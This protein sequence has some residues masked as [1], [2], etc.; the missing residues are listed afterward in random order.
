M[1]E[2]RL[3]RA[4]R[5]LVLDPDDRVLL[6]R[7]RFPHGDVWA[8]PGGGIDGDETPLDA[9]RRELHE[10]VGLVDGDIGPPIW[11]RTHLF[12]MPDGRDGQEE[13]IY[14]VR[15]TDPDLTGALMTAEELLAEGVVGNAWWTVPELLAS[16]ATFAPTRLPTL[17][18]DLV[19]NGPPDR[20]IDVGV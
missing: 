2:L 8:T 18:A 17:V 3:R 19:A 9:V 13:A 15:I 12:P 1:E 16:D 10:E 4:A 5:A 11:T 14:L 7:F 20:P 6:V